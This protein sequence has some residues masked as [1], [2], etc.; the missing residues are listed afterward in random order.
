MAIGLDMPDTAFSPWRAVSGTAEGTFC[1]SFAVHVACALVTGFD[2]MATGLWISADVEFDSFRLDDDGRS[3]MLICGGAGGSMGFSFGFS[4]IL[5]LS[6]SVISFL[7][8]L[9]NIIGR[10]SSW[11]Y[12]NWRFPI[13]AFERS[14]IIPKNWFNSNEFHLITVRF[15]ISPFW[16]HIVD[17]YERL[18]KSC[19]KTIEIEQRMR[20]VK[21]DSQAFRGCRIR[22]MS[23]ENEFRIRCEPSCSKLWKKNHSPDTQ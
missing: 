12:E 15:S 4:K 17:T 1:W 9:A 6:W 8:F 3:A 13:I 18:C 14:T 7:S 2:L 23:F 21:H 22:T 11:A 5:G 10:F 20:D 19:V 16:H